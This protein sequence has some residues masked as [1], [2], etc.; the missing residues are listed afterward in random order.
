MKALISI[1]TIFTFVAI[2]VFGFSAMNPHMDHDP[3]QV[4][5]ATVANG[6]EC[7]T[8]T[9]LA[10]FHISA[11]KVFSSAVFSVEI[12]IVLLMIV[13]GVG[14]SMLLLKQ[15]SVFF[16][17]TKRKDPLRVLFL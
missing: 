2:A 12:F 6:F 17:K 7:P 11:F 14:G 9:N 10:D 4:C 13:M 8:G 15:A 5:I 16:S 3:H 1:L